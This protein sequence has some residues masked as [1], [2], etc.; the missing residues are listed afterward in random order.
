MLTKEQQKTVDKVAKLMMENMYMKCYTS[1]LCNIIKQFGK[2]KSEY[3]V[4]K[5]CKELCG[6]LPVEYRIECEKY[7]MEF[8]RKH[9]SHLL[10]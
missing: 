4:K 9:F 2:G 3:E 6:N 7:V 1:V 8:I 5:M 10:L